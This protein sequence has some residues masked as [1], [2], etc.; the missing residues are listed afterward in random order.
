MG[1]GAEQSGE[2]GGYQI[3]A[4]SFYTDGGAEPGGG[5]RGSK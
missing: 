2:I 4:R 1:G 3:G 5:M